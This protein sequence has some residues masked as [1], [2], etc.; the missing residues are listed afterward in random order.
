MVAVLHTLT[1]LDI[2]WN[3]LRAGCYRDF[4]QQLSQN[5]TLRFVNL[6]WNSLVDTTE[7]TSLGDFEPQVVQDP[8]SVKDII[9][10]KAEPIFANYAKYVADCLSNFVRHNKS[11]VHFDLSTCGLNQQVFIDMIKGLKRAKSLLGLHMSGNPGV[12]PDIV[13]FWLK[14]LKIAQPLSVTNFNRAG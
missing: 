3:D 14:Y 9:K 12:C 2:S 13:D 7:G 6:S 4:L 10:L 5:R 1:E 8:E 11:L